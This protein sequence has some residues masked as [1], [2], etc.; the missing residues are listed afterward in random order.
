MSASPNERSLNEKLALEAQKLRESED[1][2]KTLVDSVKDY[3]IF[4]MSPEGV[5]E[6]WNSG[7]EALK[8]YKSAEII[9]ESFQRFY[10]EADILRRHPQHELEV[11]KAKGRYEEEG[12]RIRKDGSRFWA[13]VVI[14]KLNDSA[15]NHI[16]FAKVTRDLTER[17][18]A[19]ESLKASEERLKAAHQTLESRI[20]ERT[21]ELEN[22]VRSRDEFLSIASHEL[23]TPLTALKIQQ[24]LLERHLIKNSGAGL[25]AEKA[26]ELAEINGRQISQ[27]MR[28]IEDMLDVSRIA[29]GTLKLDLR[30]TKISELAQQSVNA[31]SPQLKAAGISIST[32]WEEGSMA[33]CDP[34]R[35]EQVILNL[36]TNAA[37][38]G[39]SSPIEIQT[40]RRNDQIEILVSDRGPG[41]KAEDQARIFRRFERAVSASEASGLGLG[42]YISLQIME[43]HQGSIRVE[44]EENKGATFIVSLPLIP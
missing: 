2:F 9:G 33:L 16:G 7:A 20:A 43:A 26:R 15:G 22:A 32:K 42:L 19:E 38:Y 25:S 36:L 5:I 41:I 40:R 13:N 18:R 3:A 35:I 12:W 39:R 28:L 30:P 24:Q 37:R 29:N 34:L 8:G 6:S 11:A 31:F 1:R 4:L 21:K 44:S 17:K 14:T 27:L 10:T 23:R